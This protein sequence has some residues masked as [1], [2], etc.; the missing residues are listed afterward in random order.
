MPNLDEPTHTHRYTSYLLC[1]KGHWAHVGRAP[2]RTGEEKRF[3]GHQNARTAEQTDAAEID[4]EQYFSSEDS[5]G[6]EPDIDF[7]ESPEYEDDDYDFVD[8][9][10]GISDGS[11]GA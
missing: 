10:E 7:D 3:I 8:D 11:S 5:D 2:G 4:V 1:L 6:E 9:D